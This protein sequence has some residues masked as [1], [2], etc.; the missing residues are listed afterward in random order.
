M[1]YIL[2]LQLDCCSTA[3]GS[4][5]ERSVLDLFTTASV[6][7]RLSSYSRA[8]AAGCPESR[9]QQGPGE[10]LAPEKPDRNPGPFSKEF[11]HRLAF[12]ISVEGAPLGA[13]PFQGEHIS[14]YT[15]LL[16]SHTAANPF[17]PP[18]SGCPL[19]SQL[20]L[21]TFPGAV[22]VCQNSTGPSPAQGARKR[23]SPWTPGQSCT[24][25]DASL[26]ACDRP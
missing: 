12:G 13:A 24:R 9:G 22:P 18:P 11:V 16:C 14:R 7:V 10:R 2:V 17:L 15:I 3:E 6:L 23:C 8:R 21:E 25:L 4:V 1:R 20:R 19:D 5:G 26:C